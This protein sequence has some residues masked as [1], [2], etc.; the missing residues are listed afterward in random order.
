ME[1]DLESIEPIQGAFYSTT[2][3]SN[4][5]FN[6][7]REEEELDCSTLLRTEDDELEN[8]VLKPFINKALSR[9]HYQ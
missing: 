6:C 9:I 2:T 1:Y 7:F 4:A 8:I 5:N 3:Y